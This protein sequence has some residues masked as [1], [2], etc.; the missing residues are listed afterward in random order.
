[1]PI[2]HLHQHRRKGAGDRPNRNNG[3]S[4]SGNLILVF[5]QQIA[6][7]VDDV[8]AHHQ[9][10]DVPRIPDMIEG[11]GV[12]GVVVGRA[13]QIDEVVL[14]EPTGGPKKTNA[15]SALK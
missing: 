13:K 12:A 10:F 5:I 1:V 4:L 7:H 15:W 8:G 2:T 11:R 3:D 6:V 9:L 14:R